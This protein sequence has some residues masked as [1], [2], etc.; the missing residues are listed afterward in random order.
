MALNPDFRDLFAA[1]S[2][3]QIRDLLK[4]VGDRSR[5]KEGTGA[6][7]CRRQ[8]RSGENPSDRVPS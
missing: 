4:R 7:D 5:E 3:A 2:G 8:K 6:K 1:F